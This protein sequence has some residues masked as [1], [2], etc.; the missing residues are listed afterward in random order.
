MGWWD[1]LQ[2][3]LT[4]KEVGRNGVNEG[5]IVLDM[6]QLICCCLVTKSCLTLCD[7]MDC[8]L[9]GSYVNRI[10]LVRIL[11]WVAISLSRGSS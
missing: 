5:A 9:P 10:S 11:E 1:P 6:V 7:P 2:K 4:R 3:T 8:S